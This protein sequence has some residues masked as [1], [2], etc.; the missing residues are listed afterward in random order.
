V[1]EKFEELGVLPGS[2]DQCRGV[3]AGVEF[4][5]GTRVESFEEK[6]PVGSKKRRA[7]DVSVDPHRATI[8]AH[9]IRVKRSSVAEPF[10]DGVL[11]CHRRTRHPAA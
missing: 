6:R 8:R 10:L 5:V 9:V 11:E 1:R 4:F 3:K 2:S 7:A